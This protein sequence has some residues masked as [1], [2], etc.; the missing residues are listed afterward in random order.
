MPILGALLFYGGLLLAKELVNVSQVVFTQGAPLRWMFPLLLTSLPYIF[1]MVLPMAAVLG[2]LMGTQALAQ[3]SELVA[4]QGLGVGSRVLFKP[5]LILSVL[6]VGAAGFNAHVL[7]PAMNRAQASLN[8]RMTEEAKANF[9]KPG[10]P[11][12]VVPSSPDHA[13]WVSPAGAV[14]VLEAS[15]SGIQHLRADQFSWAM[16]SLNGDP[17]AIILKLSHLTGCIW[18]PAQD[19]AIHLNQASQEL[20]FPLPPTGHLLQPT[21]LRFLSTPD[22]LSLPTPASRVELAQR[23]SLPLAAAALLLVGI[24]LGY[25]HPRFHSGGAI[26]KS[27]GVILLFY[28]IYKG[29]E[30][31]VSLGSYPAF[32]GLM[33]LP[34]A[35][36]A[37]GWWM[38]RGRLRPHRSSTRLGRVRARIRRW[39]LSM[40][41]QGYAYARHLEP[42]SELTAHRECSRQVLPI[43][44]RWLWLR[45]WAGTLGSLLLLYFLAE[46]ANLAG[47][48]AKNS[49]SF[50]LFLAYWAWSLPP[51][52]AVA[53]PVSFLLGSIMA[54]SQ[55]ALTQEW[56]A[57]K[58]GGVS[59]VSWIWAARWAWGTV[60]LLTLVLQ[61]WVAPIAIEKEN[62]LY[63]QI[64]NRS[65][66]SRTTTPWLYLGSTGVMWYL[67]REVRWGFPLKA[68]GEAPV[69]LKWTRTAPH[70]EA[71]PWGG[72]RMLQGP[73]S[74]RLF[75]D[76]AL[77]D[78]AF[79]EET[80]TPDLF[81]WQRWAPDPSRASLLWGRLLGWLAGPCL[82]IALLSFAFPAPR[83]GRGQALGMALVGGLLYL[84][85]QALF[86]GAARAGEVPAPWGILAPYLLLAGFGLWRL[87]KVR[88]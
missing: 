57:L 16:E 15:E 76:R 3:S 8:Q 75:P 1:G 29:L 68:P 47:D 71:L 77:R 85:L 50:G 36:L 34:L 88:T 60:L 74:E 62:I 37:W 51:F 35:F 53:L 2:G 46:Y 19:A 66:T 54:M 39:G 82:V 7:I 42:L 44:S 10:A 4:S 45:N 17:S 70:A 22:L 33:A 13:L 31:Q 52:L 41:T 6:L 79:A 80:S 24:A 18:S 67:D 87:P 5:W 84:G 56:N 49:K 59:L 58:A 14:H 30:N 83:V 28:L 61:A 21:P 38:L 86:T 55:A 73:R 40:V 65:E 63:R 26:L 64:L 43:W 48:L 27:L 12:R 72:L 11:P 81:R 23:V 9:L 69:L 32:Y 20:R 25:G 78:N